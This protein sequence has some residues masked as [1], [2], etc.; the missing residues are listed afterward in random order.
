MRSYLA[1]MVRDN[2]TLPMRRASGSGWSEETGKAGLIATRVAKDR[3]KG[4]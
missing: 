4:T 1:R 3:W 2:I